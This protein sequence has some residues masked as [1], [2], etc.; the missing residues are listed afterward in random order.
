M[1]V[2]Q[3]YAHDLLSAYLNINHPN[4]GVKETA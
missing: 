1:G 3:G 4:R 2:T